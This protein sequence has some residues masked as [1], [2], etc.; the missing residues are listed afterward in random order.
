MNTAAEV[1]SYPVSFGAVLAC[2]VAFVG[3]WYGHMKFG[4]QAQAVADQVTK[5]L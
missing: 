5:V 2:L 1:V 4:K 3:G